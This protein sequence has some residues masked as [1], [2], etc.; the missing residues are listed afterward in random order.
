[1]IP[2]HMR[3]KYNVHISS[4]EWKKKRE[5]MV[6]STYHNDSEKYDLSRGHFYC[7]RCGWNFHKHELEVHHLHYNSLGRESSQD[8]AVVC[9]LCHHELDKIRAEKGKAASQEAY[10][11]AAFE[12]WALKVYGEYW[13]ERWDLE[14]LYE[15]FEEWREK[16]NEEEW[17]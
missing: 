11:N 14:Y 10:D 12:G 7:E 8:L 16:K 9:S 5:K 13:W 1:M 17:Y 4:P 6:Q 15:E 2:N 3:A